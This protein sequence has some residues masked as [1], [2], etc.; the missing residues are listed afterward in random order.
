[1]KKLLILLLLPLSLFSGEHFNEYWQAFSA[2]TWK[3]DPFT[4]DTYY[5]YRFFD[6]VTT[7]RRIQITERFIWAALKYLELRLNFTLILNKPPRVSRYIHTERL[8]FEVNPHFPLCNYNI[9]TRNRFEI[10]KQQFEPKVNYISRHRLLIERTFEKDA[11]ILAVNASDEIFYNYTIDKFI[12]NRYTVLEVR[13]NTPC[14]PI[15]V[16]AMVRSTI[17]IGGWNQSLVFGTR[18]DF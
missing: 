5:E 15:N 10:R 13:L 11:F 18:L 6:P 4:I 3:K 17:A 12:E 16:Y 8:E 9:I 1:M 14:H 7:L 2:P